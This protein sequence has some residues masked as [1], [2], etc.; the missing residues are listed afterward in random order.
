MIDERKPI[1][2]PIPADECSTCGYSILLADGI[3]LECHCNP[4][5]YM[6]NMPAVWPTVAPTDWCGKWSAT[7]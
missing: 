1:G 5:I 6:P 2:P 3:T 4:P 7:P